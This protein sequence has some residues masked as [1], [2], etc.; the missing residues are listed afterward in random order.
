[1]ER[2]GWKVDQQL[3]VKAGGANAAF[4]LAYL[5]P[6]VFLNSELI[7]ERLCPNCVDFTLFFL[8]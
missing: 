2:L 5:D 7:K 8:H 6:T 4:F 1:L 3:V